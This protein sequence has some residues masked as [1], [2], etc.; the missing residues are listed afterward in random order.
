MAKRKLKEKATVKVY[1]YDPSTK[2]EPYYDTYE[3]PFDEQNSVLQVLTDIREQ[4]DPTLAV[5]ESCWV[6]CCLICTFRVNGKSKVTCR[7]RMEKEMVIEPLKKE[8]VV[9]DLIQL[10]RMDVDDG[11]DEVEEED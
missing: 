5:R 10:E 7:T 8:R 3:V 6:G 2:K 11:R 1:R 9:R 4:Q